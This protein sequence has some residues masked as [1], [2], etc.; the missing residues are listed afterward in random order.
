MLGALARILD[1]LEEQMSGCQVEINQSNGSDATLESNK[2]D[3]LVK[4][5]RDM[6]DLLLA[7]R[8]RAHL[9]QPSL[10]M[11]KGD[12]NLF[13]LTIFIKH[14]DRLLVQPQILK[15]FDPEASD[16]MP[17]LPITDLVMRVCFDAHKWTSLGQ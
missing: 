16:N 12:N 2:A 15:K 3:N 7:L 5:F 13:R 6:N 9:L 1:P 11:W 10:E 4:D 17:A 14:V 8:W